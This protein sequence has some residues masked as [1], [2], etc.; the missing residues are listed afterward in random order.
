MNPHNHGRR[1]ERDALRPFPVTESATAGDL[2]ERM[3]DTAFQAR[4]LGQ[5]ARIWEAALRDEATIF[6]GFAGAMVPA[7]MRPL[8]VY[9]IENRLIDV[10]VSTGA[11]LYHDVYET[12]GFEH[13]QGDPD[14][15]DMRL[16]HLRVVR[17]YDVLAPEHEF[18]IGERFCTEFSLTLEEDR[19]YTTR[20]YFQ[21]LGQALE[22]VKKQEG[23]ITAAAKHGVPIYCPAFGDSVHG[24][25]VA[26]GRLRTGKRILFDTIGDV[27]EMTHM[28]LTA[29]KTGVIYVGGGTPKNYIQQCGVAG[30]LFGRQRPGHSYGIQITMDQ[31]QWGGLSGCTFEEAQSWRKISPDARPTARRGHHQRHASYRQRLAERSQDA[32][33]ARKLPELEL[34]LAR[35]SP[36]LAGKSESGDRQPA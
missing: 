4:N 25:A 3:A 7:G 24:L 35:K 30:Y 19:P 17:F 11:N 31:P 12:L 32:I 20:E 26:E 14:G 27:L 2:V 34:G 5:A 29:N 33:K 9:L 13:A 23:I 21:M 22:P 36:T 1:D 28:S 15:D 18:S 8:V 10:I 6:F 16:A